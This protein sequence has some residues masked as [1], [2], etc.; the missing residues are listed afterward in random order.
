MPIFFP[1][2]GLI[3]LDAAVTLGVNA[4]GSEGVGFFGTGLKYAI[5]GILRLGGTITIWRGLEEISFLP[6]SKEIRGRDFQI[7]LMHAKGGSPT[8]LGFTTELGKHWQPWAIIRELESNARDENGGGTSMPVAPRDGST[9]IVVDCPTL[10][11]I[12]LD[13]SSFLLPSSIELVGATPN[14]TVSKNEQE[15]GIACK[16]IKI[17][18]SIAYTTT[19]FTYDFLHQIP[20]TED[21]TLRNEHERAQDIYNFWLCEAPQ[22]ALAEFAYRVTQDHWEWDFALPFGLAPSPSFL[23]FMRFHSAKAPSSFQARYRQALIDDQEEIGLLDF[24]QLSS[25]APNP[26]PEG[27]DDEE[28]A[29]YIAVSKMN[30]KIKQLQAELTFWKAIAQNRAHE[31]SARQSSS[32]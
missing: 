19:A 23:A 14:I 31:H 4:K 29:I 2:Q 18:R 11:A 24:S 7:I 32:L 9:L 25:L 6:V 17:T 16:G 15:I 22:E 20:L 10:D 21:R 12:W 26:A 28:S 1:N 13:R 8:P 3:D 5:A 30:T 27:E